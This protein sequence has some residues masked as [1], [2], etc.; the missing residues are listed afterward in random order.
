MGEEFVKYFVR[1]CTKSAEAEW[2]YIMYQRISFRD[3]ILHLDRKVFLLFNWF[4]LVNLIF[5]A[6]FQMSQL[7]SGKKT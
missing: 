6:S 3:S 1:I 4:F 7:R 2:D 5:K